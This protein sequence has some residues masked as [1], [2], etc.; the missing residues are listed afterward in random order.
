VLIDA[1]AGDHHRRI[2]VEEQLEVE[3]RIIAGDRSEPDPRPSRRRQGRDGIREPESRDAPLSRVP[4][5]TDVGRDQ[6]VGRRHFHRHDE[7]RS[8]QDRLST[9]LTCGIVMIEKS[10]KSSTVHAGTVVIRATKAAR[11]LFR[12]FLN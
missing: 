4:F 2:L 3:G 1:E 6:L 8:G 11:P 5:P 7:R 10:G 12:G 9:C